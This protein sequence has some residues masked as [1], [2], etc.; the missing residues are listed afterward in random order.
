MARLLVYSTKCR[1][2]GP[3]I[4]LADA[5]LVLLRAPTAIDLEEVAEYDNAPCSPHTYGKFMR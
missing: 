5:S 3:Y 1:V 2:Y 4:A